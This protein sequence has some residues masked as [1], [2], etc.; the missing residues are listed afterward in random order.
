MGHCQKRLF[1]FLNA[2]AAYRPGSPRRPLKPA[3]DQIDGF[4]CSE[5]R[6]AQSRTL[7]G[8]DSVRP[9][10]ACSA[11][12]GFSALSF[13]ESDGDFMAAV[14]FLNVDRQVDAAVANA[15][16]QSRFAFVS[17]DMGN[18]PEGVDNFPSHVMT[19]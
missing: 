12:S 19:G 3:F 13:W 7:G 9:P 6:P 10:D 17:I 11:R 16:G 2:A 5:R 8:S 4:P 1:G 14:F 18:I 15:Q